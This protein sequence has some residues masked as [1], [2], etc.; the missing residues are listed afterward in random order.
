MK[1][2][3]LGLDH[4]VIRCH[5]LKKMADFYCNI[6]GC[7]LDR[8]REELGLVHLR[9]G[10]AFIDLADAEKARARR[11]G[12]EPA[13]AGAPNM[14]H[15]CL[16][17]GKVDAPS[18]SAYLAEKGVQAGEPV[19]RYGATGNKLSIYLDDPEGNSVELRAELS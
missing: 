2:D 4:V 13:E 15:L 1:L 18:L 5:D 17:V 6:L 7:S 8:W 12:G 3:L 11:G 10:N 9:A 14:D 19:M 16:N